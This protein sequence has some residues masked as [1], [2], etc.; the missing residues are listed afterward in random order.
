MRWHTADY[1]AQG[2]DVPR[3]L[4]NRGFWLHLPRL[5]LTCRLAGHKPVVDGTSGFNGRPGWRWVCCDRCGIRPEPQ[6]ALDPANWDIGM[7]APATPAA[8]GVQVQPG[9]WPA[10]PEGVIGGQLIIGGRVTAGVSV[11]VGNAGS[12]HVLAAHACVP[13]LGALY[14]HSDGFGQWVQRRLNPVGYESRVIEASVHDRHLSW[15]LWVLRDSGLRQGWRAATGGAIVSGY[16][17][18]ET[19]CLMLYSEDDD[20][21]LRTTPQ[22]QLRF[23]PDADP[24]RPQR[25]WL[26]S[27]AVALGYWKR[28]QAQ[29]DGFQDGW[30][31]PG[32][33][34]LRREDDRLEFAGRIDDMLKISG[35]WVSTLWVEQAIAGAA[36][37]SVSQLACVGVRTPEGLTALSLLA[38]AAP[39]QQAVARQRVRDAIVTLP[40]YRRPHWVHW[41]DALPLTATG[42]LQ[43]SRLAA[44]HAAALASAAA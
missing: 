32:D 6:G 40:T 21:L 4:V 8:F 44:L 7:R 39:G 33:M 38:I 5:T 23:A 18:S 36:R 22:T 41:V 3:A 28:P 20:G 12:E 25:I 31:C 19:L 30:Y 26:R 35:R 14:L 17:T 37:D 1:K 24:E 34:F 2:R 16:G 10:S 11:K 42:K 43:R 29:A 13:W 27:G 9:T 15:R